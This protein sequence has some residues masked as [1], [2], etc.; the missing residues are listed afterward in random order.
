VPAHS[1]HVQI[2]GFSESPGR[3]V[4]TACDHMLIALSTR[5]S[6]ITPRPPSM[7]WGAIVH[8]GQ[9]TLLDTEAPTYARNIF[10][11]KESFHSF[12]PVEK[13]EG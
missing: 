2:P 13:G 7:E 3:R 12:D 8:T 11:V 9:R 4:K 1:G 10:I 6:L 5:M